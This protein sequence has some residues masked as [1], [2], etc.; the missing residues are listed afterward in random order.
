M[1]VLTQFSFEII[2]CKREKAKLGKKGAV[3]HS[4]LSRSQSTYESINFGGQGKDAKKQLVSDVKLGS[5]KKEL[6]K[7]IRGS[8]LAQEKLRGKAEEYNSLYDPHLKRF[9]SSSSVLKTLNKN[10]MCTKEGRII[11]SVEEQMTDQRI[12]QIAKQKKD[13]EKKVHEYNMKRLEKMKN[14]SKSNFGDSDEHKKLS[15]IIDR[16]Q[17]ATKARLQRQ[18]ELDEKRRERI[19]KQEEREAMRVLKLKEKEIEK[20]HL[21]EQRKKE[22]ELKREHEK[23]E[24][25]RRKEHEEAMQKV[26]DANARK[27]AEEIEAKRRQE[28]EKVKAIRLQKQKELDDQIKKHEEEIHSIAKREAEEIQ[29]EKEAH[30]K[31]L[32]MERQQAEKEEQE[33]AKRQAKEDAEALELLETIRQKEEKE[34][35][36]VQEPELEKN[37]TATEERDLP[38]AQDPSE[39]SLSTEETKVEP[40]KDASPEEP[41]KADTVPEEPKVDVPVPKEL[42]KEK[43]TP[44]EPKK[45]EV[46]PVE[47]KK[48]E[49]APV[50]PKK[51]EV[52]PVEPKKE[53]AAP[54][55]PQKEEAAPVESQKE[56]AA[57]VESQ[58][59]EA[60]PVEPK[61]E[62][63]ASEQP[64]KKEVEAAE[65]PQEESTKNGEEAQSSTKEVKSPEENDV[66]EGDFWDKVE[67]KSIE[68]EDDIEDNQINTAA[69]E[70]EKD[71]E[72]KAEELRKA[73]LSNRAKN[74]SIKAED[75]DP[76]SLERM[77]FDLFLSADKDGNGTLDKREFQMFF[78]SASLDLR[79]NDQ[80]I[81]YLYK[82]MDTNQDGVIS[83]EEFVPFISEVLKNMYSTKPESIN[84]WSQIFSHSTGTTVFYNKRTGEMKVEEPEG[85]KP[86][87]GTN[88]AAIEHVVMD[89]FKKADRDKDG[90]I[91]KEDFYTM[92]KSKT[93]R[94]KASE[95]EL[96]LIR[97]KYDANGDSMLSYKEFFPLCVKLLMR[98]YRLNGTTSSNWVKL[99]CDDIGIIYFNK[100]TGEAQFKSPVHLGQH[101]GEKA[102]DTL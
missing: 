48:E 77:M 16:Q 24:M 70:R 95:S 80:D 81:E 45:E 54:V 87:L 56:E 30:E 85:F 5:K 50:E 19:K 101:E 62:E 43:A 18:I 40:S 74:I 3:S 14:E 94:L 102:D 61:K 11:K 79:L 83:Y 12:K 41:E 23:E 46:A 17:K 60:V 93:L 15:K 89:V 68:N 2:I 65:N 58:K 71:A 35:I 98:I 96:E 4:S 38:D 25:A 13:A 78:Q 21:K 90:F 55:E 34:N 32:E 49:V 99:N 64:E 92:A 29:K 39:E 6:P 75:F 7:S 76:N 73:A 52:A 82:E 51:E 97:L 28:A 53:E 37:I 8:Y 63:A 44:E 36:N 72:K 22:L 67:K 84:D 47:P 59:E 100:M 91:G 42:E 31:E 26:N 20:T 86:I 88:A 1:K 9:F 33:E 57:P 66:K 69:V 10:G 27:N